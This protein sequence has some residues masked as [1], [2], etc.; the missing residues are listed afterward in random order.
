MIWTLEKG[1]FSFCHLTLC[2]VPFYHFYCSIYHVTCYF[3]VMLLL[4]YVLCIFP[5]LDVVFTQHT[6]HF[7]ESFQ[8]FTTIIVKSNSTSFEYLTL[9]KHWGRQMGRNT[10][11][12][13]KTGWHS[14]AVVSTIASQGGHGFDSI[15]VWSLCVLQVSAWVHSTNRLTGQTAH[16]CKF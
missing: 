1:L 12:G 9:V 16:W 10:V 13:S 14:G 7:D 11:T 6:E 3:Y 2:C 8:S 5:V 4:C 15:S